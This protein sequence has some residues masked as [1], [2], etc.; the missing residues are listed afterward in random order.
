MS[1]TREVGRAAAPASPA[2]AHLAARVADAIV[3]R[4]PAG[5]VRWTREDGALAVAMGRAARVTGSPAHRAWPLEAFSALV[6]PDGVIAGW[7]ETDGDLGLLQ[8]G[9]VVAALAAETG[10]D[11]YCRALA[12]LRD[13]LLRQPRTRSGSFWS[14]RRH[15]FQ[16]WL[17]A[18][19]APFHAV[20]LASLGEPEALDD[21]A[22]QLLDMEHHARDPRTGL[23]SHAWDESRRQLW[24]NPETGRSPA[25]WTRA[26]GCLAAAAVETWE[27]LPGECPSRL[28][29]SAL[30]ARLAE[31]VLR[32]QDRE[33]GLW[34][35]VTDRPQEPGNFLETSGTC[36]LSYALARAGTVGCIVEPRIDAAACRAWDGVVARCLVGGAGL[37]ELVQSSAAVTLGGC[38]YQD[39][40]AACYARA[41]WVADDPVATAAFLLACLER[42]EAGRRAAAAGLLPPA[43]R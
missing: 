19:A 16:L 26:I 17:D 42:E 14:S 4:H 22:H 8:P 21:A 40:T 35:Q 24:S 32:W 9:V 37:P 18:S 11:R 10:E 25:A 28:P 6:G 38:P 27:V 30:V 1:E 7:P 36:L 23:P 12:R 5:L 31:S 29:L 43:G 34:L 39:G 33:T 41:P 2:P 20:C 13:S 15:P 3:A